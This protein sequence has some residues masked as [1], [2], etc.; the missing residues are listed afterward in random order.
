MRTTMSR[1]GLLLGAGVVWVLGF[2]GTAAATPSIPTAPDA[3]N[4]MTAP[5]DTNI[6]SVRTSTKLNPVRSNSA[7][8]AQAAFNGVCELFELCEF[9][10]NNF[11]G[12]GID[13]PVI[14]GGDPTYI[15]NFFVSPGDGNGQR[16]DNNARSLYNAD[17]YFYVYGCIDQNFQGMCAF[18]PP[19][20]GGDLLPD[21]FLNLESHAFL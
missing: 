20:S 11:Q 16:V 2:A 21:Y 7:V 3:N 9:H 4:T 19:L 8:A 14:S 15:D 18:Q 5:A 13:F 1:L 17:P 12:S 10:L 6:N